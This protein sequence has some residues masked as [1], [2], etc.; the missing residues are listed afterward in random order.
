MVTHSFTDDVVHPIEAT[1][2]ALN[3][4]SAFARL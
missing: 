2:A 1:V 3:A 4:Q